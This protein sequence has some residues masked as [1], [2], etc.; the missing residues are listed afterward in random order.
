[1][2]KLLFMF[3]PWWVFAFLAFS[4]GSLAVPFYEEYRAAQTE[5]FFALNQGPPAVVNVEQFSGSRDIG[6]F[7]EVHI[8]GGVLAD[9]G[10]LQ[11]RGEGVDYDAIVL[12]NDRGV[13]LAVL[14]FENVSS[15][16]DLTAVINKADASNRV[17]VQGFITSDRR[18]DVEREITR[19]GFSAGNVLVLE[20][21]LENRAGVI[22]GKVQD[23]QYTF[24]MIAGMTALFAFL[25]FWRF[26][27]WR[28]RRAAKVLRRSER[29]DQTP[30][31]TTLRA[32]SEGGLTTQA[33]PWGAKMPAQPKPQTLQPSASSTF[34]RQDLN[35]TQPP[36]TDL[37]LMQPNFKSVF[38]GGGS[39]FRFKTSDEIV[40]QYFGSITD[41]SRSNTDS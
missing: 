2:G 9:L 7:D 21:Y 36:E 18:S 4:C 35:D 3:M 40:Q 25:A 28:K 23:A 14:L 20:P 34:N 41:I 15:G 1:M 5:E 13:P 29:A 19:R 12:G 8:N 22:A 11:F 32:T 37:S 26:T 30:S 39:G 27:R 24:F 10:I 31:D 33:N 16:R 38:P 6:Y 17:S